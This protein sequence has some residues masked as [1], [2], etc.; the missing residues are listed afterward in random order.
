[1]SYGYVTTVPLFCV[2]QNCA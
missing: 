2:G 1:M